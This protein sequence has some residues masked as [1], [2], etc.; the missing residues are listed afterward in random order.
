GKARPLSTSF[1]PD[2]TQPQKRNNLVALPMFSYLERERPFTI[3]Y[4]VFAPVYHQRGEEKPKDWGKVH[5]NRLVGD[6]VHYWKKP[7]FERSLCIC[8]PPV[9]GSSEPGC[10]EHCL[11]RAM[12]Y[13]C[14][15]NNCGLGD[16]CTN[17][18]FAGLAVRMER[19]NKAD[20]KSA[21]YLFNAGVEV[22]KTPDRGFG[23]R[24]CRSYEPNEII[25]EYTGEIITPNEAGRRIRED[26]KNKADYY[27]ME[28][29][30]GM[31]LDATKGSIARFVNHSCEP[32][33][34]M[35]K[36]F[37]GGQP[38][39]ALFAGDRGILTGEEL[40]Y[41]YN[42]DPYS[43]KNVQECRCGATNCRGVLGPR[44]KDANKPVTKKEKE[45]MA[46]GMKRKVGEF[47][48]ATPAVEVDKDLFKKRKVPQMSKGWVY[49]DET[50]EK[51]RIEE[52][53]K[54]KEIARLQKQ[55][56]LPADLEVK[57]T[58][59]TT[60][61][62]KDKNG[63]RRFVQ[64]VTTRMTGHKPKATPEKKP[65]K[66]GRLSSIKKKDRETPRADDAGII[67]SRVTKP[68]RRSMDNKSIPKGSMKVRPVSKDA[69]KMART[70][71]AVKADD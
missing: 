15:S 9:P 59:T 4:D 32:N 1:L 49:V 3:P 27:Q 62:T 23:V 36:R 58:T 24:A 45:G 13:E 55:G 64:K 14:D 71:R 17:R 42:F 28:F 67:G 18:D 5:K 37:V 41:D 30:Q 48:G 66:L 47:F 21:Y 34:K 10:G 63:A 33:C 43:V 29:D 19:A 46:A 6:A 54:D 40:T 65:Q 69:V 60:T 26:Y 52:A 8:T 39:M 11:N 44:P 2:A 50:M 51:T 61:V 38:R 7:Y 57:K 31:I 70:M 68:A 53:R 25:T 56:I 35:L 20:K 22:I 12:D 16:L